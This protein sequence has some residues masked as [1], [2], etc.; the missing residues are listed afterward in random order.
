[1]ENNS[2]PL[3]QSRK[4]FFI[5]LEVGR[6]MHL[7]NKMLGQRGLFI[8]CLLVFLECGREKSCRSGQKEFSAR[9]GG[10]G[11]FAIVGAPRMPNYKGGGEIVWPVGG[12]E[13]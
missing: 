1:M 8:F 12:G 11:D 13:Q 2:L 3:P 5:G 9:A 10:M 6:K 7:L 4:G